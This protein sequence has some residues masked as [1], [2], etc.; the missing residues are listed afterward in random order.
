MA[1][2]HSWAI[3]FKTTQKRLYLKKSYDQSN[4]T[5]QPRKA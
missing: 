2:D 4:A 3:P 1:Q 5:K